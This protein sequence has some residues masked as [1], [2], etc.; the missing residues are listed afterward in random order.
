[1]LIHWGRSRGY[2]RRRCRRPRRSHV[3]VVP[4]FQDMRSAR[5]GVASRHHDVS[6]NLL[7]DVDVKLLNPALLEVRILRPDGAGES[8]RI[9]RRT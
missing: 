6:R 5:T 7:L 1:M 8:G 2:S 9:R 4:G 3:D